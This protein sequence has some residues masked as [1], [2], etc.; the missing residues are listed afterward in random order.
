[1]K[2]RDLAASNETKKLNHGTHS[3][4]ISQTVL[5][6]LESSSKRSEEQVN[7]EI[8]KQQN[9]LKSFKIKTLQNFH[10]PSGMASSGKAK[11]VSPTKVTRLRASPKKLSE[12]MDPAVKAGGEAGKLTIKQENKPVSSSI[13]LEK[14][15]KPT[16]DK[17]PPTAKIS[18]NLQPTRKTS[19]LRSNENSSQ[20]ERSVGA[21]NTINITVNKVTSPRSTKIL[22]SSHEPKKND[23][24]TTP[25]NL[26]KAF[27]FRGQPD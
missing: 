3:E 14:Y 25:K 22:L 18:L 7:M 23:K 26:S 20:R 5:T 10:V 8:A 17:T 21:E 9:D 1:M 15:L 2:Y 19:Q 11:P 16:A 12:N 13:N 24:A 4:P 27:D 6:N